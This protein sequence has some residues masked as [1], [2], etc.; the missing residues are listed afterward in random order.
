MS[1]P[2]SNEL[3][4]TAT[5]LV[6]RLVRSKGYLQPGGSSLSHRKNWAL[7]VP[8]NRFRKPVEQVP[9]EVV[10]AMCGQDWLKVQP[11]GTARVSAGAVGLAPDARL[12]DGQA[13]FLDQHRLLKHRLQPDGRGTLVDTLFNEAENPLTWLRRRKDKAGVPFIS[14]AQFC[15]GETL[16]RDY[17][18]ARSEPGI[19]FRWQR[20]ETAGKGQRRATAGAGLDE[21]EFVLASRRRLQR[22]LEAIGPDNAAIALEV[23]CLSRG[24]EAAERRLGYARRTG[25][26]MLRQALDSLVAH[27]RIGS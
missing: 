10:R 6:R 3:K 4:Q 12:S 18:M 23:C 26:L 24:M 25:K 22:A 13:A 7:M 21:P 14:E 5:R 19:T 1:C 8:R 20:Q 2:M 27:Y 15:A 9:D 16:R 17:E 11:D